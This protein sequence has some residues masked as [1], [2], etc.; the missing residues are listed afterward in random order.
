M[1]RYLTAGWRGWTG[2]V[3]AL[4]AVA[5]VESATA[6]EIAD[7][8]ESSIRVLRRSVT[9]SRNESNL[10][11]LFALR[12]L[13]DPDLKPFFHQLVQRE[14]WTMQVHA[15]LGL[16][17]IDP[18][19]RIDPWLVT[20]VLPET[21]EAVIAT[22]LD[23]DLFGP[24]QIKELLAWD[25]LSPMSR[26]FLLAEQVLLKEPTDQSE[27]TTLAASDN[28]NIAGLASVLLAQL[29]D[30]AALDR[31]D[32]AMKAKS[33]AER[34]EV[35][36]WLM[37]AV[38]KYQLAE[39]LPWVR[40]QIDAPDV[41]PEVA[42]QGVFALLVM[43]DPAALEAWSRHLGDA[44]SYPDRVRFGMMLLSAKPPLVPASAFDRLAPTDDEA[45]LKQIVASGRLLTS[46]G[47]A[48]AAVNA[49]IDLG[50]PRTLAWA[51]DF[52][53]TLPAADA[54]R[55]Y[56][57]VLDRGKEF[58]SGQGDPSALEIEAAARLFTTQPQ[59][60]LSRLAAA[61]D[62]STHQQAILLGL[63]ETT[64][65]EVSDAAANIRRI[66]SGRADSL[67]LLLIAKHADSLPPSDLRQLGL[68][69]SGGAQVSDI[70][71]TQAAWLYLKLA[72]KIEEGL[73]AVFS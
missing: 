38:R 5:G 63:F 24:P 26:L 33:A 64:S 15:V 28:A 60:V 62:D 37:Q 69:A 52:L 54:E 36:S 44:P 1:M 57:H 20:Q 48:A 11:L 19:Q 32:A 34:L 16:G 25:K 42:Y 43:N 61:P 41:D 13:R 72:G 29:G 55:V 12:Q 23:L 53:K 58:G 68:I 67:A 14:N 49:M 7:P 18:N 2:V 40:Q 4:M 27:L 39:A 35:Q 3:L 71:Q 51:M 45:L 17:E 66:G 65:P 10:P 30:A 73:K 21:Q 70:L 9:A 22:G 46:G 31:L 6:Q 50:H 8:V 47:D 56:Q 59:E